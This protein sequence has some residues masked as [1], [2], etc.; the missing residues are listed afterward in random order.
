MKKQ[1]LSVSFYSLKD[2]LID[3]TVFNF[4]QLKGKK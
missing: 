1:C 3:G 2:T 4:E